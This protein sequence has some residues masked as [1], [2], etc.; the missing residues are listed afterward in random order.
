MRSKFSHKICR[1]CRH[2]EFGRN[3]EISTNERSVAMRCCPAGC[4]Y[5]KYGGI[6]PRRSENMSNS[7]EGLSRDTRQTSSLQGQNVDSR[8]GHKVTSSQGHKAT[9]SQV[10]RTQGHKVTDHK[11]T[12]RSCLKNSVTT[13]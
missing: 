1:G 3:A 9:R 12:Q 10:T 2:S 4:I 5:S 6:E 11:V 13:R 8:K 7:V